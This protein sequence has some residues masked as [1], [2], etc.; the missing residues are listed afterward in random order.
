MTG[1]QRNNEDKNMKRSVVSFAAAA[2]ALA[3]PAAG[4]VPRS[5]GELA[6]GVAEAEGVPKT[7]AANGR[8]TEMRAFLSRVVNTEYCGDAIMGGLSQGGTLHGNAPV[9]GG[10]F[11]RPAE[12]DWVPVLA[13]MALEEFHRL[14]KGG[15]LRSIEDIGRLWNMVN[16]LGEAK[17]CR[18]DA[19]DALRTMA[20]EASS[21]W[22]SVFYTALSCAW[23]NLTLEHDGARKSLELGRL[24]KNGKGVDSREFKWFVDALSRC[25][26]F[27]KCTTGGELSEMAQFIVE[28]SEQC[29]EPMT[30]HF[31]E[32]TAVGNYYH[33]PDGD[34]PLAFG[35]PMIG[36]AGWEG[37]LQRKHLAERFEN[38]ETGTGPLHTSAASELSAKD[39]DLTDL[40]EVYGDWTKDGEEE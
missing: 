32:R 29:R 31:I 23:I 18:S 35:Q 11:V 36:L 30:A 6:G 27:A 39:S 28:A 34:D 12:E 38:P 9:S 22:D 19:L 16:L 14:A 24:F 37:S 26:A 5:A 2:L 17:E 21:A 8:G 13:E 15:D 7:R 25:D 20:E 1:K 33:Y 3:I 4:A 40:R 10:G